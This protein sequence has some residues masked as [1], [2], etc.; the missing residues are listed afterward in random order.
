MSFQHRVAC[1]VR[2]AGVGL[3]GDL[4]AVARLLELD[5]G[6]P[7][8][9]GPC[10]LLRLLGELAHDRRQHRGRALVLTNGAAGIVALR[11]A[12]AETLRAAPRVRAGPRAPRSRGA[13]TGGVLALR[14]SLP[15]GGVVERRRSA[16]AP[17]SNPSGLHPPAPA[18]AAR[19]GCERL[20]PDAGEV[21]LL[22]RE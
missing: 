15:P 3:R 19:L 21:R 14:A 11:S 6:G 8:V 22:T 1:G 7:L 12:L 17:G 20:R 10:G 13:G 2:Q 4:R 16:G 18:P 5:D 9:L